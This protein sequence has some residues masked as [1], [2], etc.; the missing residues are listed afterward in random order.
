MQWLG[1]V[2]AS[3]VM[4]LSM[5]M[6]K[7]STLR[8]FLVRHAHAGWPAP[9]TSDFEREL[10]AVGRA[11]ARDIAEQAILAGLVP[12]SIITSPAA[13]CR[14]TTAAFLAVFRTLVPVED[15]NLY[16][17]GTE[18]YLAQIRGNEA[19]GS[20]MLVGHNPMIEAL[21]HHLSPDSDIIAPLATGYPTAGQL[22]LD[23]PVPLPENLA[24]CAEPV[25]LLSP[26]LA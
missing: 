23:L 11:E 1:L 8:L 17:G 24:H 14:Q 26:S 22:V 25:L 7:A 18:A 5:V 12:Q 4:D 15:A 2:L 10:D 16:A 19:A 6:P 21:A 13:R 9:N 3:A 20:L